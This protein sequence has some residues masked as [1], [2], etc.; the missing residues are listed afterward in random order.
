MLEYK[1]FESLNLKFGLYFNHTK[2]LRTFQQ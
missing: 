2:D 1:R